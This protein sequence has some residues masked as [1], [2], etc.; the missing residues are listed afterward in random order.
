MSILGTGRRWHDMSHEERVDAVMQMRD[1]NPGMNLPTAVQACVEA[2]A[3]PRT[4]ELPAEPGPEVRA[5]RA[6]DGGVYRRNRR[7][8]GDRWQAAGV[9][10][11]SWAEILARGPLT[12]VTGETGEPS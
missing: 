9:Y 7:T 5:V 1:A 6:P 11:F 8:L 4:W 10:S 12:D 2:C 3:A